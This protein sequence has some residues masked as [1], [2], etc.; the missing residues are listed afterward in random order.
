[1]DTRSLANI[2]LRQAEKQQNP[3]QYLDD[4][5]ASKLTTVSG[6]GGAIISTTVNGKSV[7]FQAIPGTT[8]ADYLNAAMLALQALECGLTRVPSTTWAVMR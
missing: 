7:T 2:I 4:L 6:Q 1:M 5:I 8:I 3:R